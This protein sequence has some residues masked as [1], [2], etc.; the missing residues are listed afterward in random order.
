MAALRSV[1]QVGAR[2]ADKLRRMA[3]VLST[4][5]ASAQADAVRPNAELFIVLNRNARRLKVATD[6]EVQRM[7]LPLRFTVAPRPLRLML[8]PPAQRLAVR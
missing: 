4:H 8:P 2:G 6:G 3:A 7:Q 1:R 5:E